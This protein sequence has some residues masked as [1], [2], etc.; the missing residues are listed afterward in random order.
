MNIKDFLKQAF[1]INREIDNK[2][3]QLERLKELAVKTT[4][5]ISDMPKGSNKQG[6]NLENAIIKIHEQQEK[7]DREVARL[8]DK[9]TQIA[10][11]IASVENYDERMVLEYRYLCFKPW[12]AI[13]KAMHLSSERVYYLHRNAIEKISK[14]KVNDSKQQ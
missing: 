14:I 6:S 10:S 9:Q 12:R 7:L 13:A 5:V 8:I 11:V 4:S 2:L 3:E 1:D